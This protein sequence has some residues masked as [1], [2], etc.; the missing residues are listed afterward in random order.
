MS[1]T[2]YYLLG[3]SLYMLAYIMLI[4]EIC[5]SLNF[6]ELIKNLKIHLIVLIG[7]SVYIVY[8]L[9]V[10]VH[11]YLELNYQYF[12]ELIYNIVML[13]LLSSSLLNYFYRDNRKSLYMFVGSL[14][15]VFSEVMSFAYLYVTHHYALNL[16]VV[17]L[18]L[19]AFYFFYQ[20]SK[21]TNDK[22]IHDVLVE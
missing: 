8:V 17:S 4:I 21:L 7:L 20:Q 19:L 14:L 16:I 15:M 12:V 18:A 13:L 5:K 22:P 6:S 10:I 1:D 11:S 2:L 3:N 9:Q